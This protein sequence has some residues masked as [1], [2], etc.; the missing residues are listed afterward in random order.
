EWSK[1]QHVL[2]NRDQAGADWPQFKKQTQ[3]PGDGPNKGKMGDP[4]FDYFAKTELQSAAVQYQ[5]ATVESIE[6]LLDAIGRPVILLFHSGRGMFG[7]RLADARA[8][9]VKGI[10]AA[11]P[12]GPPIQNAERG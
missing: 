1:K 4:V 2:E 8:Q 10:I 11:E 5:D 9:L 6:Q 12:V 3:W 7:G